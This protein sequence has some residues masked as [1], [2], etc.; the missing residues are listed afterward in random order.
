M[1]DV[2]YNGYLK[3]SGCNEKII[4]KDGNYFF[5]VDAEHLYT[6]YKKL[7]VY[8]ENGNYV[9]T[10]NEIEHLRKK[11]T[12]IVNNSLRLVQINYK[13]YLLPTGYGV[14]IDDICSSTSYL[15]NGCF[16][17]FFCDRNI[18]EKMLN[19]Y[20]GVNNNFYPAYNKHIYELNKFFKRPLEISFLGNSY[21][22]Y[23]KPIK[24]FLELDFKEYRKEK[25]LFIKNNPEYR[26]EVEK[27]YLINII[28][29]SFYFMTNAKT[30]FR[31]DFKKL[32]YMIDRL[33]FNINLKQNNKLN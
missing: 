14:T 25:D 17:G 3:I 2:F 5:E 9:K 22:S 24:K 29:S 6:V 26:K 8:D 18:V 13:F 15:N 1:K 31:N 28:A 12:K 33:N 4:N 32:G 11:E 21:W 7:K 30:L 23:R 20:N 10:V 16:E 27:I 19:V